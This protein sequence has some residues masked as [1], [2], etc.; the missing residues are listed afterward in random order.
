MWFTIAVIIVIILLAF[1]WKTFF[2]AHKNLLI[3]EL[4][5]ALAKY[6]VITLIA[7]FLLTLLQDTVVIVPAGHRGVVFD[8]V[9]GV[10]PVSL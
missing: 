1:R 2:D 5:K 4:T 9:K 6:M 8:T 10:L 7:A 3:P